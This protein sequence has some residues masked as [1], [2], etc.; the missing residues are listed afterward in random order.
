MYSNPWQHWFWTYFFSLGITLFWHWASFF[1]LLFC[2]SRGFSPTFFGSASSGFCSWS[3]LLGFAHSLLGHCFFWF[4]LL[5]SSICSLSHCWHHI[6]FAFRANFTRFANIEHQTSSDNESTMTIAD[7]DQV[8]DALPPCLL[9]VSLGGSSHNSG[10]SVSTNIM[11]SGR[12]HLIS[13]QAC[14][15]PLVLAFCCLQVDQLF[16]A[17]S[18]CFSMASVSGETQVFTKRLPRGKCM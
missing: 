16:C 4:L 14:L 15:L 11:I 2:S 9:T 10:L 1:F 3:P 13:Q 18:L 6:P 12:S 5:V 17:R 8:S 7:G